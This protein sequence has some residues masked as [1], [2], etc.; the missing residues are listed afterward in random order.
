MSE[1]NEN[2]GAKD[3]AFEKKETRK[4]QSGRNGGS[5]SGRPFSK[6]LM[7]DA[8]LEREIL[9]DD[10]GDLDAFD[11]IGDG[12]FSFVPKEDSTEQAHAASKA[13]Q[14][15]RKGS[16]VSGDV[17][18]G[19]A[20]PSSQRAVPQEVVGAGSKVVFRAPKVQVTRID[21]SK[22]YPK[23]LTETDGGS[24]SKK[25]QPVV[26]EKVSSNS[27]SSSK[28]VEEMEVLSDEENGATALAKSSEPTKAVSKW[29]FWKRPSRRDEQ[30]ARI[31]DG[32]I[33]MVDLVRAIRGQLESQNE[34]NMILRDSLAHLPQAMDGLD[35]FSKSQEVVGEALEKINGQLERTS[36]KDN[37]L[38]DS[39]DGFNATLQGMDVTN[40]ATMK[41][42]DRVQDRMGD[43]DKRMETLFENVQETEEKVSE[44][45]IRLQRNMVFM[46]AIF[47]FCLFVVIGVLI[48]F[49]TKSLDKPKT[50][51]QEPPAKTQS[52]VEALSPTE[53][54]PREARD[55]VIPLTDD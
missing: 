14:E 37:R 2:L 53:E 47:L 10:L 33:E 22:V 12:D 27:D 13:S 35:K 36:Q 3:S 19:E 40:R 29:A 42:F 51:P 31:S 17:P 55:V 9:N 7:D 54:A 23:S 25:A 49:V 39:M 52:A 15:P 21:S 28:D 45:M 11:Q 4:E 24:S 20:G 41:T 16:E 34:N 5:L 46:Q 8:A 1:K 32:Y 43:S 44:S 50:S 6:I 26:E 30:L 48:F 38:V 18:F